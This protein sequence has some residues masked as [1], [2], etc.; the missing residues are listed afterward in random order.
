[1]L[2]RLFLWFFRNDTKHF[3]LF[4][5]KKTKVVHIMLKADDTTSQH[6]NAPTFKIKKSQ[7]PFTD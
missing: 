4:C 6:C 1:M 7:F 2:I 5:W 3:E